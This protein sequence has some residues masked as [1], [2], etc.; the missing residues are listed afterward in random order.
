MDIQRGEIALKLPKGVCAAL[1]VALLFQLFPP[2]VL[3][4]GGSASSRHYYY[5]SFENGAQPGTTGASPWHGGALDIWQGFY[6]DA[7]SVADAPAGAAGDKAL[8]LDKTRAEGTNGISTVDADVIAM[9]SVPGNIVSVQVYVYSSYV[10]EPVKMQ[11]LNLRDAAASG[12]A[13][14]EVYQSKTTTGGQMAAGWNTLKYQVPAGR[15]GMW[16]LGRLSVNIRT[17]L[18]GAAVKAL[19]PALSDTEAAAYADAIRSDLGLEWYVDGIYIGPPAYEPETGQTPPGFVADGFNT[20]PAAP[21]DP[22]L[23]TQGAA[24]RQSA[25]AGAVTF[26]SDKPGTVYY[27]IGAEP[28]ATEGPGETAVAGSNTLLIPLTGDEAAEVHIVVRDLAGRVSGPGFTMTIP[29][30]A[31][32]GEP[33]ESPERQA[34]YYWTF[35]DGAASGS[36]GLNP[37]KGGAIPPWQGYYSTALQVSGYAD[38]P[39]GA[40]GERALRLAKSRAES[41]LG[42]SIVD[43]GALALARKP[44]YVVSASV[45][46]DPAY[47]DAAA[48]IM[49]SLYFRDWSSTTSAAGERY[50]VRG[51]GGSGA[52]QPGWNRLRY[53]V[54]A[55]KTDAWALGRITIDAQTLSSAAAAE[56]TY[57]GKTAQQ[58]ADLIADLTADLSHIYYVDAI[59]I[60][61]AASEPAPESLPANYAS[62][63]LNYTAPAPGEL[64]ADLPGP[65]ADPMQV[66][67]SAAATANATADGSPANPYRTI[68]GAIRAAKPG[69]EI[70]VG[71]GVYRE[72]VRPKD[73]Q[74]LLNAAGAAPVVSG[75]DIVTGWTQ[76][77]GSG[78]YAA[79]MDWSLD[80]TYQTTGSQA[81]GG[82]NQVFI[83]GEPGYE[84]RWPNA[85]PAAAPDAGGLFGFARRDFDSVTMNYDT[86]TATIADADLA[87]LDGI[88]A[89]GAT[90]WYVSGQKWS[91][92]PGTVLQH[93]GGRLTISLN[94]GAANASEP[95]YHPRPGNAYYLYGLKA[96]LDADDEWYWDKAQRRL[97]L[98]ADPA[99]KLVESKRREIA[100]D[101]SG[102]KGVSWRGIAIV[103]A[104]LVSDAGTEDAVIDGIRATYINHAA[105]FD[106]GYVYDL[107]NNG[108]VLAGRN[109]T[110]Q[111]S[112]I[113][114]AAGG[115]VSLEGEDNRLVNNDLHDADYAGGWVSAVNL[116]GIGHIV[117]R[118]TIARAG[119]DIVNMRQIKAGILE[120][121][122]MSRAG[123]LCEDLGTLYAYSSD[124]AGTEIRFNRIHDSEI[125]NGIY[126][127]NNSLNFVVHHNVIYNLKARSGL[128]NNAVSTFNLFFNNTVYNEAPM[129]MIALADYPLS[130][131]GTRYYNNIVGS[132]YS[133]ASDVAWHYNVQLEKAQAASIFRDPGHGDFRLKEGTTTWFGASAGKPL[134]GIAASGYVGAYEYDPA[135]GAILNAFPTGH[136]FADPAASTVDSAR[137][138]TPYKNAV[139]DG[140]FERTVGADNY[141]VSVPW[142]VYGGGT[143]RIKR[144]SAFYVRADGFGLYLGG[145]GTGVR[146]TLTDLKPGTD[147]LLTA[148][149]QSASAAGTAVSTLSGGRGRIGV[150]VGGVVY[151]AEAESTRLVPRAGAGSSMP[152][153]VLVT[154]PFHV[155]DETE[156]V[157]FA[158]ALEVAVNVDNIGVTLPLDETG[159]REALGERLLAAENALQSAPDM[160]AAVAA[161][162]RG[163]IDDARAV[164]ADAGATAAEY[165]AQ[166]SL[167]AQA[168]ETFALRKRL[169]QA[170][171]E[172]EALAAEPVFDGGDYHYPPS[173][174][175]ALEA[176]I[177]A[178][179]PTLSDTA[180]TAAAL[181]DAVAALEAAKLALYDAIVMPPVALYVKADAAALLSSGDDW[182]RRGLS[183]DYAIDAGGYMSFRSSAGEGSNQWAKGATFYKAARFG[184]ELFELEMDYTPAEGDWPA[185]VLRAQVAQESIFGDNQD[186]YMAVFRTDHVELQKW[187]N[188]AEDTAFRVT[189]PTNAIVPGVNRIRLGV[190]DVY[191]EGSLLGVRV[192]LYANGVKVYDF[193]DRAANAI[194]GDGYFGLALY[195]PA[196]PLKLRAVPAEE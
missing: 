82:G 83:D 23:L 166:T 152:E 76:E 172:A 133:A 80:T 58:L 191:E 109:N 87:E 16:P 51:Y 165:E 180:A 132:D 41:T 50:S 159:G 19:Y 40:Q 193:L 143:A 167:L 45:Y 92:R 75:L 14:G 2:G 94:G 146:Q 49:Q 28:A 44:G 21:D 114:Y 137:S 105:S 22:P 12:S 123:E 4:D 116:A 174:L 184:D 171:D 131:Y 48:P 145:A 17:L 84:A 119:R 20:G 140:T 154:V 112:E 117:S 69:A 182:S 39:A 164:W 124:G 173:A 126:L 122:D 121:N 1:V 35:E 86:K 65:A 118:N 178:Q 100:V 68:G 149:V 111:N 155:G 34:Y 79:D 71:D 108:I 127:D 187:I 163:L 78:L 63:G 153:W 98:K 189:F 62:D 176:A 47:L 61:P 135:T 130:A 106:N 88:S 90:V 57:P 170:L 38:T 128:K 56:Q 110:L 183:G 175:T 37:W 157:V 168:L 93:A 144:D 81:V 120:Y 169:L 129:N 194:R 24:V 29:A 5:W 8:R 125:A 26:A 102:T 150:S 27:G 30:Y 32:G 52:I 9:A 66:Y 185:F 25:T 142:T 85:E 72:T 134:E 36:P 192:Y 43:A 70:V 162:L 18:N 31:G 11:D 97:Y 186:E 188:G 77:A 89:A 59:Y 113:A 177:D 104:T 147:Y 107:A 101:L 190:A 158:E 42:I 179:R 54:P 96:F 95:Y 103:G 156:A 99:G 115:L 139:A 3:A 7:L 73:G 181:A 67:V 6:S 64:P 138:A 33:P 13:F 161:G 151:S 15:T 74:S 196:L 195:P 136:D 55:G 141:S 10:G 91:S 160:P 53:E 148:R 46:V 60:G